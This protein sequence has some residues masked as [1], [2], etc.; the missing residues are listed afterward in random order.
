MVWRQEE[1]MESHG[2]GKGEGEKMKW[3]A[4][5][6]ERKKGSREINENIAREGEGREG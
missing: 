2:G 3:N 1:K 6:V 5:E 4:E